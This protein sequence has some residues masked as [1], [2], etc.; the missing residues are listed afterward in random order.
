VYQR[1]ER[2]GFLVGL[3]VCVIGATLVLAL[4]LGRRTPPRSSRPPGP[5]AP[6]TVAG[7]QPSVLKGEPAVGDSRPPLVPLLTRVPARG[8][9]RRQVERATVPLSFEVNEGQTDPRV[10]FLARGDGFT[11]FLTSDGATLR[12]TRSPPTE[13]GF[14]S[15]SSPVAAVLQLKLAGANA[16][17]SVQGTDELPGKSNYLVGQNPAKWR[18]GISHYARV[19]YRNVYPGVDLVFRGN[20]GKLEYDFLVAPGADLGRIQLLFDGADRTLVN[21]SGD[22]IIG[23]AG[24]HIRQSRPVVYQDWDNDRHFL[25]GRYVLRGRRRIGF[26]IAGYRPDQPL[27]IDP[28]LAYSSF[29]GGSDLDVAHAV[30]VDPGDNVY[31]TGE[32]AS[33]NFPTLS[34]RQP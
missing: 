21:E 13:T 1:L 15:G 14:V 20:H 5:L 9:A 28:I 19:K 11:V 17:P 33:T 10:R 8:S 24:T 6:V 16:S 7:P 18:T 3:V 4:P 25:S 26:G 27:V 34:P 31:L 2:L 32:T 12:L 30:A 29:L 23:L 22:L